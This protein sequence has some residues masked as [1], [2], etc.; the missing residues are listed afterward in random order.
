MIGRPLTVREI[1]VNEEVCGT[2]T[3]L[4]H[5]YVAL[6]TTATRLTTVDLNGYGMALHEI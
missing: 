1:G 4:Y 6:I 5:V 3:K 2:I